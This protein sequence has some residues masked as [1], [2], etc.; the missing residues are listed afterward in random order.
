[1]TEDNHHS[2][3]F[4]MISFFFILYWLL[5]L[6][7]TGDNKITLQFI[8]YE[9]HN[10]SVLPFVSW[11][12]LA[13]FAFRFWVSSKT[14][15]SF[16]LKKHSEKHINNRLNKLFENKNLKTYNKI[17][18]RAK[19]KYEEEY[20]EKFK[21]K[22]D[23]VAKNL[24]INTYHLS[25]IIIINNNFHTPFSKRELSCLAEYPQPVASNV[26]KRPFSIPLKPHELPF[27]QVIA[28]LHFLFTTES[29]PDYFLPWLLFLLAIISAFFIHF[30]I[31]PS[32][33]FSSNSIPI[34]TE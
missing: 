1:M 24:N 34:K 14:Q 15:L 2:R 18:Y 31:E 26:A 28:F 29:S 33:I 27:T 25:Y 4:K 12:L 20:E 17:H 8:S 5:D 21:S 7:P 30:G 6:T 9:I 32:S 13:Y 23:G 22:I 10:T 11:L 19:K 3:N 16:E